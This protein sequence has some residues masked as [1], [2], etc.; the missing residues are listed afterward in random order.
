M[1]KI[2]LTAAESSLRFSDYESPE[3]LVTE[4]YSEG[5]LCASTAGATLSVDNWEN[6]EFSW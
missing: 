2:F 4:V 3:A 5:V 6:G 1:N